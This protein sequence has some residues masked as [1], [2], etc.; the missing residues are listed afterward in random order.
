MSTYQFFLISRK[1]RI[2]ADFFYQKPDWRIILR[3][4]DELNKFLYLYKL[5]AKNVKIGC[6]WAYLFF[7]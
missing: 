6:I 1:C 4:G 7:S 3:F 2:V 5:L